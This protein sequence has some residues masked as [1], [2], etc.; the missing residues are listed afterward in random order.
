MLRPSNRYAVFVILLF[1][2]V[3]SAG[4]QVQ[5]ADVT[6]I[7]NPT[8][9]ANA[10]F[11]RSVA[12]I[13]DVNG[14][15]IPD[16]LVG[17]PGAAKVY[18]LSGKDQSV[19]RTVG[20]PDGFSDHRF[21]FAVANV[22]DLDGDH[23]EDFAVGAP[24][25]PDIVSQP[26][27][28]KCPDLQ[29]GRVAVFSGATGQ[30]LKEIYAPELT[31][32]F[33]YSI[34]PLGDLNGD[35]K[36]VLA[37]GAPVHGNGLGTVYAMLIADGSQLWKTREDGAGTTGKQLM[38]SFGTSMATLRDINSDGKPD[39]LVGAPFHD[40]GTGKNAG[41]AYV[42]SGA[43]GKVL[44]THNPPTVVTDSRFGI[45]VTNVADQNGDHVNDYIIGDPKNS[46]VHMFSGVDGTYLTGIASKQ[47]NDGFGSAAAL[48][49][50]YDGDHFPDFAIA[51][52]DGDQVYVMNKA[53]LEILHIPNPAPNTHSFGSALSVTG[54]LGGDVGLDLLIGAPAELEGSGAAY[55][56]T[57][58][59]NK[60]PVANAG[61][62]QI[63]ECDR[64]GIVTL[65]G[66]ASYDPDK[67]EIAYDWKQVSGTPVTLT[68]SGAKAI[69]RAAPPGVYEFQLTVSDDKGASSTD[70]VVVTIRDTIGPKVTLSFNPSTLWPPNH[71]MVDIS[72]L[73]VLFDACDANPTN[74]LVT[75]VSN[76][77]VNGT[78]DGNT[79]P[80][81]AGASYGE[82]DR[83]FQLRAE[84]KG[85]G[86][87]RIYTITYTA[88]DASGNSTTESGVVTVAHSQADV[89]QPKVDFSSTTVGSISQ[90]QTVTVSNASPDPL[91]ISSVIVSGTNG[92]EFTATDNCTPSV[93]A[94]SSCAINV[95]FKPTST[96]TRTAILTINGNAI[97][98]PMQLPLSGTAIGT[99]D[100]TVSAS[101]GSATVK[102]GQSAT[103][104][105]AVAPQTGFSQPVSFACSGLPALATCSFSPASVTPNGGSVTTTLTVTTTAP[106][107]RA[108]LASP[109]IKWLRIQGGLFV[110][111]LFVVPGI[112]RKKTSRRHS[113]IVLFTVLLMIA[114][115]SVACGG[116]SSSSSGGSTPTHGTPVGSSQV[117]V[118]A[119]A[120]SG[121]TTHALN[122]TL[123]VTQ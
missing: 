68:V 100:Y 11:G 79:S 45:S 67:D 27:T 99:P 54:N 6:R 76:E 117:S 10:T 102:Q 22:G 60:P 81:I 113:T 29:W 28:L 94:S 69:F 3:A 70:N 103:F 97:N 47:L 18:I 101:P 119:T 12:G 19:I 33:G 116:G 89:S 9:S 87:G 42:L 78:G 44:R 59:E 48:L 17:A 14:D 36:Q 56:V 115:L 8:P 25:L 98:L 52:P 122:I 53:G 31:Q 34:T 110:A 7:G 26:C 16:L 35:G 43:D 66:S 63:I 83:S 77:P 86:N 111:A 75:I 30:L 118:S 65:D 21:G 1:A 108:G 15:N 40:D 39:V 62:D 88:K 72:A 13:G 91:L 80:D 4:T 49:S 24:G 107:V 2:M 41:V 23:V 46:K 57:V 50:D 51:A 20:D 38:A 64:G 37:V 120:G 85:N 71:K 121:G 58:R 95:T 55:L 61:P 106:A 5:V 74:K 104:S 123:D 84:R 114:L 112:V 90:P 93:A 32:Q 109:G 105:I 92:S 73:V 96:G 82:D